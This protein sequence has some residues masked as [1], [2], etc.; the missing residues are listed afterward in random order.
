MGRLRSSGQQEAV[1]L[2]VP[3]EVRQAGVD[4]LDAPQTRGPLRERSLGDD[5]D[6]RLDDRDRRWRRGSRS[7]LL[8]KFTAG[9]VLAVQRRLGK[10]LPI[11][12]NRQDH[13]AC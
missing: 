12:G 4:N 3:I 8:L 11:Q 13:A 6:E 1:G 2:D 5:G 10:L 9:G 7:G